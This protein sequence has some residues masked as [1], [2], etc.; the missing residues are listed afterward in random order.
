[1]EIVEVSETRLAMEQ[2]GVGYT[3]FICRTSVSFRCRL[4]LTLSVRGHITVGEEMRQ[5]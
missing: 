1:M 2:L 4:S 3:R 5:F